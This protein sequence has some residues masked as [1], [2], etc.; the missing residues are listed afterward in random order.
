[1]EESMLPS[2]G[3]GSVCASDSEAAHFPHRKLGIPH[4]VHCCH[5]HPNVAF[6]YA[7]A[8]VADAAELRET[9]AWSAY[10][11]AVSGIFHQGY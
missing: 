5:H 11:T 1:M 8:P 7:T 2:P 3:L 4:C 10:C 6:V 9:F